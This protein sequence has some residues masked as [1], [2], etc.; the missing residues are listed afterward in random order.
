MAGDPIQNGPQ[1]GDAAK[2]SGVWPLVLFLAVAASL[3]ALTAWGIRTIL[4][5]GWLIGSI[6]SL[7]AFVPPVLLLT[8]S[9][10]S[11]RQ[12]RILL[13]SWFFFYVWS[14]AVIGLSSAV[15]IE[16]FCHWDQARHLWAA[17]LAILAVAHLSFIFSRIRRPPHGNA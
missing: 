10:L 1:P 16:F 11:R 6:V 14:L 7:L 3:A 17:G 5:V 15:V 8:L 9:Y 13:G 4:P 2:K 12:T